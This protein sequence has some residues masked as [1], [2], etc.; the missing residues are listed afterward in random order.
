MNIV[1][2]LLISA[3]TCFMC[4]LLQN[5][6]AKP[7]EHRSFKSS[8]H[9]ANAD[10]PYQF[11]VPVDGQMMRLEIK[12]TMPMNNWKS[13][14]L[15]VY[16]ENG[17][18]LFTYQDELW[19]ESGR[20][21]DGAWS[22]YNNHVFLEQ[23][24]PKAGSYNIYLT[25]SSVTNRRTAAINYT[26]RAIPIYGDSSFL[27]PITWGAGIVAVICF[28]VIANRAED[29]RK[30]TGSY[31]ATKKAYSKNTKPEHGAKTFYMV[32]CIF[33][34]PMTVASALAYRDDDDDID[35]VNASYYNKQIS[36]DRELR[37]QSL[38]G[39]AFR[40]GGSRGGK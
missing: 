34:I 5:F 3:S 29:E 28:I 24:F 26:V 31:W 15:E 18:Y 22:E 1:K 32:V 13:I 23:R 11:N 12:G 7:T 4:M 30:N 27:K 38:S 19:S 36:V 6:L 35:W 25:D 39:S 9:L 17:D 10:K 33:F 40:T 21:S 16:K 37:Q 8:R 14:E 2:L 20:D